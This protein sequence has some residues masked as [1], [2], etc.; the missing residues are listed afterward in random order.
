MSV[1]ELSR[2]GKSELQQPETDIIP[3]E[4]AVK[5]MRDSGYKNT[6][7]A[8]AELID[9][10]IEAKASLV[11]VF[12]YEERELINERERRRIKQLAV[13]DNGEGM[14]ADTLRKALQ[15]GNGTRLNSRAG[16]GRFGMGLPNASISQCRRVDVWTWQNGPDNALTAFLDLD[17]IESKRMRRV[18]DPVHRPLPEEWR[19]HAENIGPK[20]TLV[21]WQKFDEHRLTW[22]AGRATLAHVEALVGRMYRKM[23]ATGQVSIRLVTVE[24][25]AARDDYVRINDPL[26]LLSPS[27]TPAPFDQRPMFQSWGEEERFPI[28]VNGQEH[29]VVVRMSWAKPETVPESGRDRGAEAYGK[30]AA[31][32]V[33]VSV[34]RAGRE[35][36]LDDAWANSYDPVER[37][38]GVEVEFPPALDEVFGVTNNKQAARTF[39][40]MARFD[41]KKEAEPGESYMDFKRRLAAEG[42][43]RALLIDVQQHIRDQL[44][45]IR[46]RLADQ[47]KGRRGPRRHDETTVDDRA[48]TKFKERAEKGHETEQDKVTLDAAGAKK[49]QDDLVG[50]KGYSNEAASEIV[51]T[52]LQ[53]KRNVIFV[54]ADVDSQAFFQVEP[55]MGV[56]EIVLNTSHP[57]FDQLVKVLD[58]DITNA[59]DR[60]LI[61]RIQNAS[62]TVKMLLAAWARYEIEDMPNR[63][64]IREMRHEWGKMARDFLTD[65]D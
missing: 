61:G 51:F 57:A 2:Y 16:I 44:S 11:E 29:A 47:T 52:A 56:T 20:G 32:N 10:S 37:W 19:K 28:A 34:V 8:I 21:L 3:P 53:R 43:P 17:E 7:Y 14:D 22:R 27:S 62:D 42:D 15:F 35:L 64:R 39:A 46:R 41:W 4:L 55:K 23:I 12:C 1:A 25:G 65:E 54:E 5:A 40:A 6:A 30:H 31:Q 49:L 18:P 9:N 50:N 24:N 13:L 58:Q 63:S 33:G 48:S 36:E 60:D 38:W 26:Y 45:E 59:S